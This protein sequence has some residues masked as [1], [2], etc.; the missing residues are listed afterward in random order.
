MT[1]SARPSLPARPM[2]KHGLLSHGEETRQTP[3]FPAATTTVGRIRREI[4]KSM[5]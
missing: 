1:R 2:P 3:E 5:D 4:F